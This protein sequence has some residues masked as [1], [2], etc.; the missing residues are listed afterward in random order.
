[1]AVPRSAVIGAWLVILVAAGPCAAQ[2]DFGG[3]AGREVPPAVRADVPH[4]RC[5]VCQQFVKQ[6]L[7]VVKAMREE[8]KPGKKASPRSVLGGRAWALER[9]ASPCAAPR[10]RLSLPPC[11]PPL[12]LQ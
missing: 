2:F 6:G 1:M 7:R 9:R 11:K 3:G 10:C 5:G 4:I 8:L 12:S